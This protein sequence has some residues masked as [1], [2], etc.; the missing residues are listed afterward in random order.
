MKA[1]ILIFAVKEEAF[2]IKQDQ[3]RPE[4]WV[5][6]AAAE[7]S[8]WTLKGV[9]GCKVHDQPRGSLPATIHLEPLLCAPNSP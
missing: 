3:G 4:P 5:S 1:S 6:H 2:A 7:S 9:G 8:V